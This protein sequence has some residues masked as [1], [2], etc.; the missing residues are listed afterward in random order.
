MPPTK[1]PAR[2]ELRL[3]LD[4]CAGALRSV[5]AFSA[6]LN[7]L[8]LVPSLYMLQVYDRVLASRNQTT[9]LMLTLMVLA[10]FAVSGLLE[11]VRGALLVRV[12]TRL[13][14]QLNRRVYTAAFEDRLRGGGASASQ[15]LHD[16]AT[17]R[18]FVTGQGL[19]AFF[20]APW[21]PL[22]LA[23]IAVFDPWLGLFAFGGA[24]VLVALAVAGERASRRPLAEAGQLSVAAGQLAS[25]Q[26]RNAEVVE[27]MGMLPQM[28]ERWWDL[29]ARFLGLQVQASRR[30]GAL[31]AAG[32][33]A[34]TALQSLVLALGAVL[35]LEGRM[36]AGMMVVASI[37]VGRALQPVE[38][39]IGAWRGVA[40]ARAAWGRL[41]AL[42]QAHPAR[43][44]PM[45]LPAPQGH[46]RLEGV[47]ATPPGASLPA[48]R[49]VSL[50][51]EPG[52]VL[53]VIGASGS[54][55][56]TL[57]R[58]L[59]GVWPTA[60]GTVRLDG[61]DVHQWNKA[62][63]GPAIGYLPQDIELF[64]GTV[65]ENIAR[66]GP[67]D[68][69][70]VAEAA[71]L[72]GVHELVLQLPQGYDTVLGDGGAGLAGGQKQRIALAR[73]LYGN[74]VL[75]VLD[76][77][78]SNLDD[79]GEQALVE[80]IVGLKRAGRTLVLVTHRSSVL[81]VTTKLLLLRQGQV[82]KF[83]PTAT[84]LAEL[85]TAQQK[86]QAATVRPGGAQRPAAIPPRL[87]GDAA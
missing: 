9:L 68:A 62:D 78:N 64:A 12:G 80:A 25:R 41:A 67:V 29:H 44:V 53:G 2:G 24:L 63:L 35:V 79:A 77:P 1:P 48:L 17:V 34:R 31:Q 52:D 69:E 45:Q 10:A 76:E 13:D 58:L 54:G 19:F 81:G 23:L 28:M 32:K 7:L 55:K 74:P 46:V 83:G 87:Q 36:T 33:A 14:M 57:A 5:A 18:Q 65:A 39:L 82:E 43:P 60:Q 51:L 4:S 15:A 20:D 27:A 21:F 50:A 85:T 59:V 22:Y 42:L 26:L 11:A 61:A 40:G 16:L 86:A 49:G 70:R 3:A 38:Q 6:V 66:F 30:A 84:V 47:A 71:R 8:V 37:L 72:A 75:L 73:A 56:S